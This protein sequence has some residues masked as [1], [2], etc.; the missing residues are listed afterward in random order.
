[1]TDPASSPASASD[2]S[3]RQAGVAL[4]VTKTDGS[5]TYTPGGTATYVVT[6][7]NSGPSDAADVTVSDA[8]P[9]GVTLTATVT[10][11]ANGVATCGTVTGSNG[12]ASF[13]ATGATLGAGAGDSLV[14][15]VP[16]AFAPGMT[17]DPLVNAASAT[18]VATG[19]TANGNDSDAL[20]AQVS[21]A[22]TKTDGS[23]SYTPGG[24]ATLYRHREQRRLVHGERG[25]RSPT[26]FLPASRC[27]ARCRVPR[28]AHRVAGRCP[29]WRERRASARPAP[30]S[31]PVRATRSYSPFRSH[32]R[33]AMT[34][35]PLVNT[36][37]ATDGPSGATGSGS[38][39]DAR[40]AQVTLVVTKT[41]NST[42]YVPGGTGLYVVTVRNTGT[43]DAVD[44]T[45]NDPL[46][47]GVTL[48]GAVQC[49]AN[50]IATCGAVTG[51]AGETTFGATGAGLG[52]GA[53]D[54]LVFTAPVAFAPTLADDPLVNTATRP[55]LR[56]AR[57]RAAPTA[58]CSTLS[59]RSRSPRPTTAAPTRRAGRAR[60]P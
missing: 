39:S 15:T 53:G 29:E 37:T 45:F 24:S 5:S 6:V 10:C 17:A 13:G 1:M 14:F 47:V 12:E 28:A 43:S 25:R 46:P 23:N 55:T 50:G 36:A 19:A 41:D 9:A 52:T 58:T 56:R 22:V 20:A 18:D 21:L 34:T 51:G 42:T 11:A 44:I 38:D 4:V 49:V 35:D 40:S 7:K 8:L 31:F 57:R 30:S 27:Q 48:T 2:S 26:R 32:S 16:V 54:S 59:R 3:T 60:T 33:A